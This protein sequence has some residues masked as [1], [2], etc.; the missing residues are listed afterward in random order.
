MGARETLS[1]LNDTFNGVYAQ[2]D[3]M[4]RVTGVIESVV[5]GTDYGK[6]VVTIGNKSLTMINK[7][8][9]VLAAGDHV[10]VHY[11]NSL[12][13]G[14]IALR[15]GAPNNL[16]GL[17]IERAAVV[18]EDQSAV[19]TVSGDVINIDSA[20]KLKS[21]YGSPQ[22]PFIINEYTAVYCDPNIQGSYVGELG[23][24]YFINS[25]GAAEL[26]SYVNNMSKSLWSGKVKSYYI[27]NDSSSGA[28]SFSYGTEYTYYV[29]VSSLS[30]I[31]GDWCY[32]L[33]IF[34]EEVPAW[35][36]ETRVYFKDLSVLSTAGLI[37]VCKQSGLGHGLTVY[38]GGEY[39][40]IGYGGAEAALALCCGNPTSGYIYD[41]TQTIPTT[42]RTGGL[43]YMT[44][45]N[46]MVP[47]K[48]E[49]EYHYSVSLTEER[50][51][52]SSHH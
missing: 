26:K 49:D 7:S 24:M 4:K 6:A 43:L 33:G 14:Y 13:D 50:E 39:Q 34:C 35:H 29:G 21:T 18:S 38:S 41:I 48:N 16:G 40:T 19:Y 17:Y 52:I 31:N 3:S 10:W 42:V 47:F 25:T 11:W 45:F 20:N 9:E 28:S 36:K 37:F 12:A 1:F 15:C 32:Y 27:P 8:G 30:N 51:I 44:K 22:N 5:P 23:D 2:K 46:S